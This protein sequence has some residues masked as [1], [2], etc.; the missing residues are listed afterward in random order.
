MIRSLIDYSYSWRERNKRLIF[1]YGRP[2]YDGVP[3]PAAH[4]DTSWPGV[5]FRPTSPLMESEDIKTWQKWMS[6]LGYPLE[7]DGFYGEESVKACRDFQQKHGLEVD[8]EVGGLTWNKACELA[9]SKPQQIPATAEKRTVVVPLQ[10]AIHGTFTCVRNTYAKKRPVSSTELEDNEKVVFGAGRIVPY[11][12]LKS[13]EANHILIEADF[14]A[15]TWYFFK[16]HTDADLDPDAKISEEGEKWTISQFVDN[17]IDLSK[18][19]DLRLKTQWAYMIAT[20][21]WETASTFQPV[22]EAFWKDE[23][24]RKAN[25]R[26]YP[27]YGRGYVQ[28][29]WLENYTKYA[30]ILNLPLDS[31][32]DLVMKPKT[33]LFILVDGFKRGIFTSHRLEDHV[34]NGKTDFFNA[35]R[36]INATDKAAEIANIAKLWLDKI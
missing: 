2:P 7:I 13:A 31:Q 19:Y 34:N 30:R 24:W 11:I 10:N 35:R 12:S 32:P 28:L 18:K 6:I 23:A 1:G 29:T 5:Y 22:R 26:Y 36:C 21:Q 17:L 20:A 15:G 33:S 25:F 8:G 16:P 3:T 27:Y 14:S 9:K 4:I